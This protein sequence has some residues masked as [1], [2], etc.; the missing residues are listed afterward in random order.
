MVDLAVAVKLVA[1]QVEQYEVRGLEARE[2]ADRVEL[3]AFEHAYAHGARSATAL[4]AGLEQRAGDAGLHV[5]S[6][7]VAHAGEAA[8]GHGIGDEVGRGGLSVGAGD[9]DARVEQVGE[10]GDELRIDRQADFAGQG[11]AAAV[12]DGAEAPAGDAGGGGGDVGGDAHGSS[13]RDGAY[14]WLAAA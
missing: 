9:D 8:C 6:R 7:A 5:V 13:C 3:V 1:E 14:C 4:G 2:H 11:A 10:V 12:Q